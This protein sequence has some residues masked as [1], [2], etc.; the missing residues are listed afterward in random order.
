M[1][2]SRYRLESCAAHRYSLIPIKLNMPQVQGKYIQRRALEEKLQDVAHYK[3][4]LV[5]AAAGFG[6]TRFVAE[7]A[8]SRP[9]PACW[10][11]LDET[12][13]DFMRFWNYFISALHV[14]HPQIGL[15]A[16][17]LLHTETTTESWIA[18]L[19]L[20]LEQLSDH[21]IIILDNY[22]AIE[23]QAIHDMVFKLIEHLPPQFQLVIVTRTDPPFSLAR[24]R[25]NGMLLEIRTPDLQFNLDETSQFIREV[26]RLDLLEEET[27]LLHERTEGWPAGL[28]IAGLGLERA[29]HREAFLKGF[30]GSHPHVIDY[31]MEE[32]FQNL[33]KRTRDF[34]LQT[35]ILRCLF[36]AL[37][38]AV[39]G[40]ENAE[41]ILSDLE[42]SNLFIVRDDLHHSCYRYHRLFAEML[43]TVLRQTQPS[44]ES[45]LHLRASQWCMD[46]N[47]I[48]DA[49]QHSLA[50]DDY[51]LSTQII[52]EST[53]ALMMRGEMRQLR[54]W[55][56][57]L[58]VDYLKSNPRLTILYTWTLL[59]DG[60]LAAIEGYLEIAE[61]YL[62]NLAIS[63]EV[64]Q[65]Y[66][67]LPGEIAAIRAESARL[68]GD[69]IRSIR[70]AQTSMILL[71]TDN[72]LMRGLM[73][74]NLSFNYAA[75]GDIEKALNIFSEDHYRHPNEQN[76]LLTSVTIVNQAWLCAEQGQLHRAWDLLLQTQASI[77]ERTPDWLPVIGIVEISLGELAYEW[78][79]LEQAELHLLQGLELSKPWLY[80]RNL[81]PGYF[82]LAKIGQAQGNYEK[83]TAALNQADHLIRRVQLTPMLAQLKAFMTCLQ[84]KQSNVGA[85]VRWLRQSEA[86]PKGEFE[87][88]TQAR[89]LIAVQRMDEA[90]FIL[91]E[92]L[93][94]ARK[95]QKQYAEIEILTLQSLAYEAL[96]N[97]QQSE[98]LLA[99]A[100]TLA[101]PEGY[102]RLFADYQP[103]ITPILQRLNQ[104][105]SLGYIAELLQAIDAEMQ[106]E[107]CSSDSGENEL[108][109]SL[110]ER[111]HEVLVLLAQG[112]SNPAIA[113]QLVVGT[114]T[115][116]THVRNI[117]SKLQVSNR[118]QAVTQA[119]KLGL[120]P[121]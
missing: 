38:T 73:L 90:F 19:M 26:L 111:E 97:A 59:F 101:E 80:V 81:L 102:V 100:L 25:A 62:N 57:T 105:R 47:L 82:T 94:N 68:E 54:Q 35:S 41:A 29:E 107:D 70:L 91:E 93:L 63:D 5:S 58:P 109:E 12:D 112:L 46:N 96:E 79:D 86:Q 49:I 75:S 78:N 40:V 83:V 66:R 6:K 37:C 50:L 61:S 56:D 3:F 18:A 22:H 43:L 77:I 24:M 113:D 28:Q 114:G 118:T 115:V 116:K 92:L 120:L 21:E 98:I 119:R 23:N 44:I 89:V 99:Q 64:P 53:P 110:T 84:L 69:P 32:V 8:A 55:L 33:P 103:T 42:R 36:P 104:Q 20:D 88:L 31:L 9:T 65:Q 7:F 74:M 14:K 1:A 10:L 67:A 16:L 51:A 30:S 95:Q 34:L 121:D 85:A 108:V 52:V 27:K 4:S 2:K 106:S 48:I 15:E 45:G 39:T 76:A 71:P 60:Q 17:R 117:L 13:N 72:I 87:R 11:T